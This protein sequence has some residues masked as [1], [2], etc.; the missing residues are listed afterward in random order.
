MKYL[1]LA[2]VVCIAISLMAC[3]LGAESPRGFNLPAGNSDDGKLVLIKYKCLACH[4]INGLEPASDLIDNPELSI[5]LGGKSTQV[6]TYADLLT[7]V[8]N[9]SHKFARGYKFDAIQTDGVS[10]MTIYNDVMTV[11]ELIDLVTFLQ[12]NY[13]LIP[14]K[15]N[16]YQSY[17]Y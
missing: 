13:Q 9:P 3:D 5:V 2:I 8:I 7:S 14:Y 1:M 17:G 15:R 6:K 4:T 10:K 12:S 16:Y 11:T